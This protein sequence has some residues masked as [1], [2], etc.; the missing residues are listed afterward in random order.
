M[1]DNNRIVGYYKGLI[2][3]DKFGRFFS[4]GSYID[5]HPDY[6]G[7]GLCVPFT[8]F[9]YRKLVEVY[10]VSYI[11]INIKSDNNVSACKCYFQGALG[12]NYRIYIDKKWA[13]SK[14]ACQDYTPENSPGMIIVTTQDGI[15]DDEMVNQYETL[16]GR[17]LI[18]HLT[19]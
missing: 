7:K 3:N 6:R 13:E 2:K 16:M 17:S 9:T 15:L 1:I 4:T 10:K 5:I 18:S 12:N 19:N 14:K 8:E 11:N